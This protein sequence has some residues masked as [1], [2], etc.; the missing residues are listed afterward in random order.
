M[1]VHDLK[2]PINAIINTGKSNPETQLERI[3]QTGRQMLNLVMNILDVS[4]YE[5]A[6]IPLTIENHKLLGIAARAT[7]QVFFLS[8]EKNITIVNKITPELGV[9]ADAEIIERVFV[10][11]LTNAIKFT[12]NNGQIVLNAENETERWLKISIADN[13]MGILADRIHLVF[14]KFGQ[15]I[16][17]N[18][19]SVRSTGLGLA[20]CKLAIE[21]HG[22]KIGVESDGEHGS[23]FWFI[24]K[25]VKLKDNVKVTNKN[26][27]NQSDKFN[28]DKLSIDF[29]KFRKFKFYEVSKIRKEL[30]LISGDEPEI[31]NWKEKI[32]NAIGF[33]NEELYLKLTNQWND[34][35]QDTDS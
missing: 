33:G 27:D 1:I 29:D 12:P 11:I 8:S 35:S 24:L 7:D 17:K 20:F 6:E 14:Q 31:K 15:V 10:N 23:I 3:K 30:S 32:L 4:K 16:A 28:F 19:G 13:G 25:K 34:E 22:G 9:R 26:L 21:A 18:S 2:N 5:E